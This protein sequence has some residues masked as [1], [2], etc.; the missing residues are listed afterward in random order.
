[1]A[2][3]VLQGACCSWD[4]QLRDLGSVFSQQVGCLTLRAHTQ[5]K[6]THTQAGARACPPAP[7]AALP[8]GFQQATAQMVGA[9]APGGCCAGPDEP[10]AQVTLVTRAREGARSLHPSGSP[11]LAPAHDSPARARC[12]SKSRSPARS[13]ADEKAGGEE[14]EDEVDVESMEYYDMYA[15]A[16]EP[17]DAAQ[18]GPTVTRT[19]SAPAAAT[20]RPPAA[21]QAPK[22][23]SSA[24]FGLSLLPPPPAQPEAMTHAE[25]KQQFGL[26]D[27]GGDHR[28]RRVQQERWD[29]DPSMPSVR[30][31]TAHRT[32]TGSERLRGEQSEQK[33]QCLKS[34]KKIKDAVSAAAPL[35]SVQEGRLSRALILI[36]LGCAHPGA[37][38]YTSCSRA[39]Y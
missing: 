7:D 24:S 27:P 12:T 10:E 29:D 14:W 36:V 4:Q 26:T 5:H 3:G 38:A 13:G 20:D 9:G 17:V 1:M 34:L 35:I 18:G 37:G 6:H 21:P 39:A 16:G 19:G 30:R 31:K 33:K 15:V 28:A 22:L 2:L 32:P 8:P 23:Y 25:W 11:V